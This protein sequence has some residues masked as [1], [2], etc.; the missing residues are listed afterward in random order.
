MAPGATV[1]VFGKHSAT[2]VQVAGGGTRVLLAGK[3]FSGWTSAT[4]VKEAS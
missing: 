2:V 3:N 1:K 4:N